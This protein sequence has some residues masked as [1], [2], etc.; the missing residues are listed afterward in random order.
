[1]EDS[2]LFPGQR[3]NDRRSSHLILLLLC[4]A[5]AAVEGNEVDC[6]EA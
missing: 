3:N 2:Y 6:V 1:M 4:K 5:P